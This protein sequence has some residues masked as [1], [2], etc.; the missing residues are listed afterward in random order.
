M[1]VVTRS[2]NSSA[3]PA[4]MVRI[5]YREKPFACSALMAGGI[6]SS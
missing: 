1:L 6:E 5:A 3:R 2:S 4:M